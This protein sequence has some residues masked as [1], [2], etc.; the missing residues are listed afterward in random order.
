L[1]QIRHIIIG[2]GVGLTRGE[3]KT[4]SEGPGTSFLSVFLHQFGDVLAD[5][6]DGGRNVVVQPEDLA[7]NTGIVNE[8]PRVGIESSE[9]GN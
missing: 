6:V 7:F 8:N 9:R 4:E 3:H 2:L 5:V 1:V